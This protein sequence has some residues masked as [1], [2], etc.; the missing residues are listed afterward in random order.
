MPATG[1]RAPADNTVRQPRGRREALLTWIAP[2]TGDPVRAWRH[3]LLATLLV[4][5]A[6]LASVPYAIGMAAAIRGGD[7]TI[8]VVDTTVFG[9]LIGAI[10]AR[11]APFALRAS[12][13]VVL[14]MLLGSFLLVRYGFATSGFVWLFVGPIFAALLFGVRTSFLTIAGMALLLASIGTAMAQGLLQW[15]L[16]VADELRGWIVT[17][18]SLLPLCLLVSYSI[19]RIF[20]GLAAEVMARRAAEEDAERQHQLAAIGMATAALAHDVNNL[21]QP[22][23][24]SLEFLRHDSM[25]RAEHQA[26]VTYLI[27]Q[28]GRARATIRRSLHFARPQGG[29]REPIRLREVVP[30]TVRSLQA[31]VPRQVTLS[32]AST[33][34][35]SADPHLLADPAELQQLLMLQVMGAVRNLGEIG[36]L[37]VVLAD[38]TVTPG[39]LVG[40]PHAALQAGSTAGALFMVYPDT[41]S[42]D[43]V[44]SQ[45][46]TAR[47]LAQVMRDAPQVAAMQTANA[48]TQSLGGI[49]LVR[50][51]ASGD[52]CLGF[53]LPQS[54]A[55]PVPMATGEWQVAAARQEAPA[56]T[57]ETTPSPT[58]C[59]MVVDDEPQV[60]N[61]TGR[62]LERLGYRTIRINDPLEV[63]SRL[64][65][66]TDRPDLLLADVSMP[67]LDGI[68]LA[69]LVRA[70]HRE[71]PI[72]LMSGHM[73]VLQD[74]PTA[75]T[76]VTAVLPKPFTSRELG[77]TLAR[78]LQ[79]VRQPA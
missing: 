5:L 17:S 61:A 56:T 2:F 54:E 19:G 74:D 37:Q 21:L 55:T 68:E 18:A 46:A 75:D 53:V 25:L 79:R 66:V 34:A 16:H 44:V 31:V 1:T 33:N 8:V 72:V 13:L 9:V 70:V 77:D 51:C 57:S 14:P 10:L 4:G 26:L 35:P 23:L 78:A 28:T 30:E 7:M 52:P 38:V 73:G 24:S 11:R 47:P 32:F 3:R 43:E 45:L 58:P 6:L 48:I 15:P 59:I 71:L 64:A 41:E 40:M 50:R 12:L 76:L 20:E 65:D 60:L 42:I 39:M 36:P 62:L 29:L 22:I 27:D 69:R 67:V 63:M 49:A